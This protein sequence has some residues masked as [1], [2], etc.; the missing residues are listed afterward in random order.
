LKEDAEYPPLVIRKYMKEWSL[1]PKTD[2]LQ[3][4]RKNIIWLTLSELPKDIPLNSQLKKVV[5]YIGVGSY[6]LSQ[7]FAIT[8]GTNKS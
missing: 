2:K 7:S 1:K 8:A 3:N 6:T 5:E 4:H